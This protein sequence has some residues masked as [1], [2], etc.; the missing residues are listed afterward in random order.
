ME[1][2]GYE[3]SQLNIWNYNGD[4]ISHDSVIEYNSFINS[5]EDSIVFGSETFYGSINN[6]NIDSNVVV[7]G[8]HPSNEINMVNNYWGTIDEN[9]INGMIWDYYDDFDLA[10]INFKP[11]LNE[12]EANAG[13]SY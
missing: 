7:Q 12:P 5:V 11:F 3:S 13:Y 2:L 6:N 10:K 8:H 9:V 4:T 1:T